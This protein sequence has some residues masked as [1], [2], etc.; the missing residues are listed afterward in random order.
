MNHALKQTKGDLI[1]IFDCDHVATRVFLQSTVGAFLKDPNLALLQTPHHFYSPD[2]FER[3]L[4][5]KNDIPNEGELFYGP[6]QQGNDM[7]NATFFCGS[8]AVLR[9][10][11]LEQIGGV[12]VETVTEDAHTA[13]KMQRLGWNTAYL[14]I[15]LAGGLATERLALHVIQRN[16]WARG[17]VQIFRLDNPLLGKGLKFQQRLCYL[18]AMLYFLFPL[19]RIVFDCAVG[20][21]AV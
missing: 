13:L 12:A 9:R 1:C 10:S 7:W 21:F 6:I 2:P 5:G 16:R 3:N 19:P 20:I 11:A 8:C 17:M 14:P 4:Y 15:P 18:S